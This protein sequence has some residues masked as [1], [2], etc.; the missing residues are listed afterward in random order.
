ML[1]TIKDFALEG[2]GQSIPIAMTPSATAREAG[3]RYLTVSKV[4]KGNDE[5]RDVRACHFFVRKEQD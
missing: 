3:I 4:I 2:K 5:H 1:P